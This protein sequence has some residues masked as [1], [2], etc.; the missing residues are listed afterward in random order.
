MNEEL[1]QAILFEVKGART[2]LAE[3]KAET[4]RRL[5]AL[6]SRMGRVE[7]RL[8]SLETRMDSL[9]T[10]MHSLKTRMDSLETKVDV[11]DAKVDHQ[12]ADIAQAIY[13]VTT[14]I[15]DKIDENERTISQKLSKLEAV[16]AQ[17]CY[18]IQY[19]KQRSADA[20]SWQAT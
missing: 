12:F 1:L 11:L 2:D 17:N 10:Q 18:D 9:E 19:L 20:L 4:N 6:E 7:T 16:V 3:F 15:S 13:Q 8:D 14:V 5:D